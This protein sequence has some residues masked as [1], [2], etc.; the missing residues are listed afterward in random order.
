LSFYFIAQLAGIALVILLLLLLFSLLSMA[1]EEDSYPERMSG[2]AKEGRGPADGYSRRAEGAV[3]S[4]TEG[5]LSKFS[6]P[7]RVENQL[8]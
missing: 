5:V 8:K 6:G 3:N 4:L 7:R 2:V 1:Q